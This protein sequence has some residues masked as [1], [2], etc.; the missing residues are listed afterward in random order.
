MKQLLQRFF[1]ATGRT[2]QEPIIIVSGLPRSGTSLM[3]QLLEAGGVAPLTDGLREAD[4]DNP[5]GYY[6]FERVKK[7]DKGDVAWL[8]EAQ[9]RAVK[10]I[11]ALVT[12]LPP[13]YTYRVLFVERA[14]SETL[15]SQAKMLERRQT[16]AEESE[17]ADA[18]LLQSFQ[19]HL[20]ETK[21]WLMEQPN[22]QTLLVQHR[23]LMENALAQAKR[24]NDFLG[25]E[26]DVA[27]MAQVIDPNLYRNQSE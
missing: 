9:G 3:M 7:L 5:K 4:P 10:V 13:Q 2:A 25:G 8:A 24:I 6:E 17:P 23:E 21:R 18:Q 15:A 11:S 20:F 22:M 19:Q 12:Y 14:L 26:L 16:T 27:A 1:G